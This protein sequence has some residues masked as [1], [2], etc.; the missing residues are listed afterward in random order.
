MIKKVTIL[1]ILVFNIG[2]L[3]SVLCQKLNNKDG[4]KY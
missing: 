1:S 3:L 4:P 2:V